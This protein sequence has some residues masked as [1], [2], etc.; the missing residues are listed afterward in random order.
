M[1]SSI[2]GLFHRDTYDFDWLSPVFR[3]FLEGTVPDVSDWEED[4]T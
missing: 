1:V 4:R 3:Q 2:R